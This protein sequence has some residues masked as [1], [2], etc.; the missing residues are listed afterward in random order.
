MEN[1]NTHKDQIIIRGSPLLCAIV[2]PQK[3]PPSYLL[4]SALQKCRA[5]LRSHLNNKFC[6]YRAQ[7]TEHNTQIPYNKPKALVNQEFTGERPP[8]HRLAR[9]GVVQKQHNFTFACKSLLWRA[10]VGHHI[11]TTHLSDKSRVEQGE[12]ARSER[13]DPSCPLAK[14]T[15]P[16][17]TLVEGAP[18]IV[19]DVWSALTQ[20]IGTPANI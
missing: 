15:Q 13:T 17:A 19:H 11:T 1:N 10:S 20:I 2:Q 7:S 5:L 12:G 9:K 6:I 16:T 4:R 18:D 14:V 3:T 8:Q